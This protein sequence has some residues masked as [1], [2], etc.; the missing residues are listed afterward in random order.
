[1]NSNVDPRP[2]AHLLLNHLKERT[3]DMQSLLDTC[4]DVG[5]DGVYRFY[6][7]SFKVYDRLQP[8][9]RSVLLCLRSMHPVPERGLHHLFEEIA[10]DGTGHVFDL[11]HNQEWSRHTRPIVE[12][13]LHAQWFLQQCL[14]SARELEAPPCLLPSEWAAV[15][16]LYNL[17]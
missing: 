2:E 13:Y 11:S 17:R 5:V 16:H 7:G 6:H 9:T 15:L 8:I 3:P 10:A 1:M 4:D 12:A 14:W